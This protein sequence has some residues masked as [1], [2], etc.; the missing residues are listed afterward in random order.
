MEQEKSIFDKFISLFEKKEEN[1]SGKDIEEKESLWNSIASYTSSTYDNI[2]ESTSVA[3]NTT[4]DF[5]SEKSSNIYNITAE[6]FVEITHKAGEFYDQIE[7]KDNFY[8]VLSKVN[9]NS[10]IENLNN[11]EIKN[12]KARNSLKIVVSLLNIFDN[13]QKRNNLSLNTSEIIEEKQELSSEVSHFMKNID[14]K[15]ILREVRPY[16]LYI[17]HPAAPIVYQ[18]LSFLCD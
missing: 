18:L 10:L 16:I 6:N 11:V 2:V 13:Y 9:L 8:K 5:I 3:Y 12:E 14:F 17:P 15:E 1:I 7:I 4:I